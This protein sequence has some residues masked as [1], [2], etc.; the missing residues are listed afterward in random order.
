[1]VRPVKMSLLSL[2]IKKEFLPNLLSD[3]IQIKYFHV[4]DPEESSHPHESDKNPS[5]RLTVLSEEDYK[6]RVEKIKLIQTYLDD[7]FAQIEKKPE[8]VRPP[9]K[10]NRIEFDYSSLDDIINDLQS[11][12]DFNYRRLENMAKELESVDEHLENLAEVASLLNI[13]AKFGGE[14][15]SKK[16]YK[17]LH[18]D[19]YTASSTHY[20]ELSGSIKQLNSPIV[21]YGE[22]ISDQLV[23]FFAFYENEHV[24]LFHDL[25]LSY[26]CHLVEVSSKYIDEEG[27]HMERV[28]EDHDEEMIKRSHFYS[29]YQEVLATLPQTIMAYYETLDNIRQLLEIEK[30]IQQTPS[31]NTLKIEGFIPASIENRVVKA[32]TEQFENNIKIESR[33]IQRQDPYLEHH[34]IVEEPDQEDVIAPSLL[35]MSPLLGPYQNLIALYGQ[36]NY[37][38]LNPAFILFFTFPILFGFMFGD[39]GHGICLMGAGVLGAILFRKNSGTQSFSWIIFYCGIGAI[40]GGFLY[41]EAFGQHYFISESIELHPWLVNIMEEGGVM[42]IVKMSIIVGVVVI[43]MGF[44]MRGIN[45]ALN[46]KKYLAFSESVFKILLLVGGAIVILK[47]GFDMQKWFAPPFPPVLMVII[48]SLLIILLQVFGKL[49]GLTSYLKKKTY[50]EIIGHSTLDLAETFLAIISNVAS[51]IR[52]LALEMAHIGLMLVF[53]KIGEA[54]AGPTFFRKLIVVIV[55]VVGN[56]FVIVLETLLVI[57]HGLRL[58]FYEFFSKFYVADGYDFKLIEIEDS[59]S[60]LQFATTS[61][62]QTPFLYRRKKR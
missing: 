49:F 58:H 42:I 19:L 36:T 13:I 35:N 4:K 12:V 2:Y 53:S 43:C 16:D 46:K 30:Q 3:L 22:P 45:Y 33:I 40:F 56:L 37:S 32:L 9:K 44:A 23:G 48:P 47:Y 52:I 57:I 27:I 28:Q 1:M 31:H 6:K 54:L 25:F 39:I 5:K 41:G 29:L 34:G 21:I 14:S 17:R 7:I 15:Y 18:F 10:E 60:N 62:L 55:I 38:E 11:R 24:K 8:N 26:N 59:Y 51:F 50:G 61:E 20:K